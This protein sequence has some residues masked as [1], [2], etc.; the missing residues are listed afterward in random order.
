MKKVSHADFI[1]KRSDADG[2]LKADA[3]EAAKHKITLSWS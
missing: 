1:K 3:C 2:A